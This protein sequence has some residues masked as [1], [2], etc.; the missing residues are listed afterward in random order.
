[1]KKENQL[2]AFEND[3]LGEMD[4]TEMAQRIKSKDISA[5]EVVEAIRLRAEKVDPTLNTIVA[6]N[7]NVKDIP[8]EGI[9]AGVPIFIKDL[10]NV[11]G[12][13]TCLGSTSVPDNIWKKSD[14]LIP[15][16]KALGCP[17]I[18]K[19]ATSEFGLLPSCE[20][21]KNGFT[22][23]PHHLEYSTGGSS[24]GAG[25]L[26]AAGI[27]P[28]AHTMDGG[29]STRIPAS[30]CGLVGLKPSRGRHIDTPTKSLPINIACHGIVSR[31][32]RDTANY[33]YGIE[34]FKKHPKLPEIGL[35]NQPLKKRLKIG[36]FTNTPV[37]TEAHDDVK[38]VIL[39]TGKL[40]QNLGHEVEH[41]ENPYYDK[42][43]LDF[44]AY[45]SMLA[46]GIQIGG[47]LTYNKG[48]KRKKTEQF[49]RELSRYFP[50]LMFLSFGATK[51]L[52]KKLLQEY[53]QQFEKY[54]LVLSPVLNS[55]T[56][57]LG[58]FGTDV[59]LISMVMK[60]NNYVNYTI[61][62]NATG[63][64]GISLPMGFCRN[65]LPIGAMFGAKM[66]DDR[67]LLE[68]GLELEAADGFQLRQ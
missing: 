53:N 3:I 58:Y 52:K 62:Q 46:R 8:T 33:Y 44:I 45:Y 43:L 29:G 13:P 19:S 31:T 35:V 10:I 49:S 42:V 37:G 56:A 28:I 36:M 54:D 51:R 34:Q 26:V 6:S 5:Q 40:C 15:Q 16:I 9:F 14:K 61:I 38:K 18:G 63:T 23:N 67:T 20:T 21:L 57:K 50:R 65:G 7:Y 39:D 24:G 59:P 64:P 47:K 27:S 1:M 12:F 55:P 22:R 25:A 32:M 17:I 11:E 2:F 68:L 66:G 48:F 30:C 4:A 41:I 60:M